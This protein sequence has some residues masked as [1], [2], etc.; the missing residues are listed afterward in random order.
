MIRLLERRGA[1]SFL[2]LALLC[3]ALSLSV[4]SDGQAEGQQAPASAPSSLPSANP[5]EAEVSD[6]EALKDAQKSKVA[7]RHDAGRCLVDPTAISDLR[8][9][10]EEVEARAKALEAREQELAA[11]KRAVEEDVKRLTAVREEIE[12]LQ[13]S[14]K[15]S[16]EE[17]V[18]KLV[19]TMEAMAPKGAAQ[20]IA[21]V[22]DQL[23]VSAMS[24]LSTAKLAKI[25][26]LMN[27]E[28]SAFLTEKMAGVVRAQAKKGGKDHDSEHLDDASSRQPAREAQY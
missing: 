15:K 18:A 5:A 6:S 4:D 10:S 25:L 27:P 11:Q 3:G 21:G 8:R 22:D 2:V 13:G 14:M 1:W 7:L 12:K 19:E 9:R 23:A 20:L 26:P 17:R 16:G 28:R 24:R